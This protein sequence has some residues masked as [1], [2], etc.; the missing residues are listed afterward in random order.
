MKCNTSWNG[1]LNTLIRTF[2]FERIYT[3]TLPKPTP[4]HTHTHTHNSTF[5]NCNKC[6]NHETG[7]K[8]SY[9]YDST[10]LHSFFREIATQKKL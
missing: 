7:F 1:T 5:L 6:R 3:H 9:F 8:R 2:L 10:N 4:T